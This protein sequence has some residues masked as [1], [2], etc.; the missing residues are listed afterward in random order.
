MTKE[1]ADT[2][3]EACIQ[4]LHKSQPSI[5]GR[6]MVVSGDEW[7][8]FHEAVLQARDVAGAA[9]VKDQERRISAS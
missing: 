4:F 8:R 2:L 3:L 9:L 5:V 1:Q 7:D 6:Q